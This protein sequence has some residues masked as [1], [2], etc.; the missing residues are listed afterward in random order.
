MRKLIL[1]LVAFG[2]C[3]GMAGCIQ[4][5]Y[6]NPYTS[7][8]SS[9]PTKMYEEINYVIDTSK[10][11]YSDKTVDVSITPQKRD[12][13]YKYFTLT[14]TNKSK[15]DL[16]LSWNES[17]FLE[18]DAA[19]GG[20]MFDGVQYVNRDAPKQDLLIL[21]NTTISKDIYPTA[22]VGY[23][24]YDRLAVSMGLPTGWVH[25]VLKDGVFGA[26]LKITGK[27]YDNSIKVVIGI[28]SN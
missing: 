8:Y 18:N 27:K 13:N 17:Y 2:L 23:I 16:K 6:S 20:F 5:P 3:L 15:N 12:D 11:S 1:P 28:S 25:Y 7:S 10:S 19:N 24:S 4:Q 14:I 9:Q 22:K 26:Y 21:P